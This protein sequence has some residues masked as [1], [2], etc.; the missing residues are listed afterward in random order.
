[1]MFETSELE[2]LP[3]VFS[4]LFKTS[5]LRY[6]QQICTIMY[7]T[8]TLYIVCTGR[9]Y[10]DICLMQVIFGTGASLEA[11]TMSA[12]VGFVRAAANQVRC[13]TCRDTPGGDTAL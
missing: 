13:R 6:I 8:S 1:M 3:D 4:I 10:H 11:I 12:N 9:F 2:H 5:G 7:K